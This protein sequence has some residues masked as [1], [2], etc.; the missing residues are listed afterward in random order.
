MQYTHY[1]TLS[2]Q[3]PNE[4]TETTR[5]GLLGQ[6]TFSFSMPAMRVKATPSKAALY[7][8]PGSDR[9]PGRRPR[10]APVAC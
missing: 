9:C 6:L 1:K 10:R 7:T 8:S 2:P 4:I 3:V 5:W